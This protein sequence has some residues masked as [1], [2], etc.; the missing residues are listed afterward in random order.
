MIWRHILNFNGIFFFQKFNKLTGTILFST[1]QSLNG[2]KSGIILQHEEQYH[3]RAVRTLTKISPN[4]VLYM[5]IAVIKKAFSKLYTNGWLD[6]LWCLAPLS[7]IF[8]LYSGGQFYWWRKLVYPE[9]TTDLS[10]ICILIRSF[11]DNRWHMT[12]C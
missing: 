9:R 8:Q 1:K 11:N 3:N 10:L 4:I 6:G 12:T 7:I 5:K 2:L